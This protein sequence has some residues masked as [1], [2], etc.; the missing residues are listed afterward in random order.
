MKH[1]TLALILLIGFPLFAIGQDF[2]ITAADNNRISLHFELGDYSI[3]TIRCEGEL[4]HTIATKGIALPNDYGQPALPTFNRFIAIPQGAKA[5]VEVRTTRDE[6]LPDITIVPSVGS[7]AENDPERPFFKDPKV[8]ATNSF[9]PAEAYCAAKPQRLRG[10]DVIHL[11]LSPFQFNPVTHELAVHRT[12][13]IDIRFEGGNGHFG[14]DRLRSRYWDPILKNNILNYDCLEPIDY[15]ARMQQW[16]SCRCR[17]F[18][19]QEDQ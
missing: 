5:V 15:D 6:F 19:C 3:D 9:Y 11:G 10:V 2:T 13:D 4:M 17:R 12:M 16:N 7:Q 14:D 18:D 8:Y 1:L